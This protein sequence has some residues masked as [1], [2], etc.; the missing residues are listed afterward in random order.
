MNL[1][2]SKFFALQIFA[3]LS[4]LGG[5]SSLGVKDVRAQIANDIYID[6]IPQNPTPGE[7]VSVK[8]SSYLVNLDSALI[9]WY[10][11][12]KKIS[13]G[14]G[15]KSYSTKT[16]STGSDAS[17]TVQVVTADDD[18]TLPVVIRPSVMVLLW[19]ADSSYVPPFYRGK[20]LL[21]SDSPVKIVALPE[22]R[23]GSVYVSPKNMTYSWRKDYTNDQGASGYGKNYFTYTSDY[24][25]PA[26]FIEVSAT[27]VDGS[28]TSTGSANIGTFQPKVVF[29]KNDEVLGPMFENALKSGHKIVDKEIVFAAPYF[30]SAE[31]IRI[32]R[33]DWFWYIN[34]ERIANQSFQQNIIPLQVE[35]GVSGTSTLRLLIEHKD[36]L[37]QTAS[38]EINFEF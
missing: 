37:T 26:S 11:N 29:Y 15:L 3:L 5:M 35:S 33:L 22:I 25:D 9:T 21:T 28:R 23:Q 17:V 30:I 27:T 10:E 8:L 34:N 1:N 24:L 16:P 7:E 18:V 13:S 20:A 31:D 32:P 19:E 12:N 2:Y 4:I 6:V 14:I 38:G 36:K